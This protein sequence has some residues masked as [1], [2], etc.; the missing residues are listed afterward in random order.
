MNLEVDNLHKYFWFKTLTW[1]QYIFH[2]SSC[3]RNEDTSRTNSFTICFANNK[4]YSNYIYN[5][6]HIANKNI[7][8][9]IF[10]RKEKN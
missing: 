6:H 2:E 1:F 8:F 3:V 10:D 4:V 5:I 7:C 9:M